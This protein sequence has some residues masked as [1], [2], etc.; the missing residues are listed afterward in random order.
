[1]TLANQLATMLK[2]YTEDVQKALVE[3]GIDIADEAVN[4]LHR[5]SPML[6]G[7]Y[8]KN[9]KKKVAKNG[10]ITIY[11]EKEYRIAHL[12]EFGHAKRGGGRHVDAIVH[13]EPIETFVINAFEDAFKKRVETIE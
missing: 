5:E 10:H 7:A 9:W 12:L 8:S 3:T 6:T 11:N 13:I 2:N 1:M 4:R